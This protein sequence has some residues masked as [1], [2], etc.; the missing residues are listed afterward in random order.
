MMI[1]VLVITYIY[2]IM[3]MSY[4]ISTNIYCTIATSIE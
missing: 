3:V 4:T 2:V 1:K